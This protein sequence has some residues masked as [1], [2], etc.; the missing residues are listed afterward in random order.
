M[1]KLKMSHKMLIATAV[2]ILLGVL[3]GEQI[4]PFRIIGDIFLRLLQMSVIVLILGHIIEAVAVDPKDLARLGAKVGVGFAL[5]AVLGSVWGWFMGT[6]FAPGRGVDIAALAVADIAP[7]EVLSVSD[8]IL[9]FFSTNIVASMSQG[10][11]MHVII[12]GVV[13]GIAASQTA[14]Q[15][16]NRILLD[17]I[18]IFN[19]TIIKLL[20]NIMVIAPVG[21]AILLA[22]TIGR[23]GIQIMLPLLRFLV[24]YGLATLTF[25]IIVHLVVSIICK[26]NPI[27]LASHMTDMVVMAAATGSSAIT[28]PTVLRDCKERIGI[29]SRLTQMIM[30][31]GVAICSPG[32]AMHMSIITITVAQMFGITFGTGQLIYVM[33]I[34]AFASMA[35]A[36]MPGAGILSL[37][38]MVS[39]TGLPMESI[40]LFASIEWFIGI[41]RTTL[42][43]AADVYAGI[44]IAKAEGELDYDIY[45]GVKKYEAVEGA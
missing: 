24:V 7:A 3:L 43:V 15:Q 33:A 1:K 23:L 17:G 6:V 19:R 41:Y 27:R 36:V 11:I 13:F 12:F 26:V 34:A 28:L 40:A 25:F 18:V 42:N 9:G 39:A 5:M 4:Q 44:V 20:T 29:S 14:I 45:N 35:N 21:V 2:G 10:A 37:T 8:T 31:L 30:P 38:I 16:N 32:A 22:T